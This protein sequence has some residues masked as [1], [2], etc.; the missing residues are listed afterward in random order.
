MVSAPRDISSL[1]GLV[2][3]LHR[4]HNE[5]FAGIPRRD[6]FCVT[7]TPTLTMIVTLLRGMSFRIIQMI[8]VSLHYHVTCKLESWL[9]HAGTCLPV[10]LQ[11]TALSVKMTI[12]IP[13]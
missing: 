8:I 1:Y 9:P 11:L 12:P 10:L 4:Q 5:L 6:G 3:L 7:R 13:T 2:R